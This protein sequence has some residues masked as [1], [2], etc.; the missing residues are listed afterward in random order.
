MPKPPRRSA[1]T[2]E[3]MVRKRSVV[4][5]LAAVATAFGAG[6]VTAIRRGW[7]SHDV[8]TTVENTSEIRLRSVTIRLETCGK[9]GSVGI[10]ALAPGESQR[11]RYPVCGE[12]GQT[13]VAEFEDGRVI[14]G[15]AAYVETGYVCNVKISGESI[16]TQET[17]YAL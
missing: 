3:R 17:F 8:T 4:L 2:L 5:L 14:E 11:L 12:G 16:S 7:G 9:K 6:A 10:E 13:I 1:R 15:G